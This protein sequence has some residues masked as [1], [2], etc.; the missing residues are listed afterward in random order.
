VRL[1]GVLPRMRARSQTESPPGT[2]SNKVLRHDLETASPSRRRLAL[3]PRHGSVLLALDGKLMRLLATCTEAASG[4]LRRAKADDL[5]DDDAFGVGWTRPSPWCLRGQ[6][7]PAF[8]PE[9]LP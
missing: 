1:R 9:A 3:A 5:L 2:A 4:D 7:T 8:R 6:I